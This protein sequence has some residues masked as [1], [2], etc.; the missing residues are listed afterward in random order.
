MGTVYATHIRCT[1]IAVQAKPP[2]DTKLLP[3]SRVRGGSNANTCL[4]MR[5]QNLEN[6]GTNGQGLSELVTAPHALSAG[7]CV[8]FFQPD[9]VPASGRCDTNVC[10][11][12]MSDTSKCL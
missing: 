12:L 3:C 2:P 6:M 7:K 11:I 4:M 8:P 1:C 10:V 5:G 9:S